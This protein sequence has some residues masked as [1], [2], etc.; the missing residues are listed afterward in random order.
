MQPTIRVQAEAF[1]LSEEIAA[2]TAGRA[3]VG[4]VVTFSGLCRD[5]GGLLATL[6]LEYYPGMAEKE[7]ASVVDQA[8]ERWSLQAI[9]VIHRHGKIKPGDQIVLVVTASWH[10]GDAFQA[11]EFLMDFLKTRAPFW[12]RQ[13]L[14][15]GTSGGWVSAKA[16]DDEAALR[17][18]KTE[19]KADDEAASA[20][21]IAEPLS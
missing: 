7:I 12:K 8:A 4:A 5:E 20:A 6:E 11:A 13:N 16:E 17:W 10:R 19:A 3:D 21:E 9:T 2:I 15:D 18:S 14:A 1:N